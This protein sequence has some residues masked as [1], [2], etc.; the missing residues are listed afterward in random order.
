MIKIHGAKGILFGNAIDV[1][2]SEQDFEKAAEKAGYDIVK[3]PAK[4]ERPRGGVA[5]GSNGARLP[6]VDDI[7]RYS[8]F[9]IFPNGT[10]M[11]RIKGYIRR[12]FAICLACELVNM[13]S[14]FVP[15]WDDVYQIKYV[16]YFTQT[17]WD[18]VDTINIGT[19]CGAAVGSKEDSEK[20]S[21][22]LTEWGV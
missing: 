2:V 11:E 21:E 6:Y 12:T 5:L 3:K 4:Y 18:K 10:D 1:N 7:S 9:N 19:G 22:L 20:V 17:N 16:P 13:K 8:M 15:D 14:G